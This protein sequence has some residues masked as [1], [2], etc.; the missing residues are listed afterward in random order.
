MVK[1]PLSNVE[2]PGSTPGWGT[3][4]PHAARCSQKKYNGNPPTAKL[5]SPLHALFSPNSTVFRYFFLCSGLAPSLECQL[6]EGR[7]FCLF[8][9]H[10]CLQL[11][12]QHLALTVCS[13]NI[14][15]MYKGKE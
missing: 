13:V 12:G 2:D 10:V 6:Y 15:Y 7:E 11:L 1:N 3:K 8:H 9:F 5:L 14:C 4:I